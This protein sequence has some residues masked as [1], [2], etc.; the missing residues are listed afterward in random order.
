[1]AIKNTKSSTIYSENPK[2]DNTGI[3]AEK[4]SYGMFDDGGSKTVTGG[5]LYMEAIEESSSKAAA[6]TSTQNLR[7]A[8]GYVKQGYGCGLATRAAANSKD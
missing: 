5:K 2:M 1:M 4:P 8:A 3:R 6:L 7:K